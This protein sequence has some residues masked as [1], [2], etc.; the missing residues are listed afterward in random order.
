MKKRSKRIA[1]LLILMVLLITNGC[2]LGIQYTAP[3]IPDIAGKEET[4]GKGSILPQEKKERQL[5]EVVRML[6]DSVSEFFLSYNEDGLLTDIK[7]YDDYDL[8]EYTIWQYMNYDS[9]GRMIE[10]WADYWPNGPLHAYTYREDGKLL[11]DFSA[12]GGCTTEYF[13][14]ENGVN[15]RTETMMDEGPE[16]R[17]HTYDEDGQL[18]GSQV[19][20]TS[21]GTTYVDEYRYTYDDQGRMSACQYTYAGTPCEDH[22]DYQYK[23]FVVNIYKTPNY[24]SVRISLKDNQGHMLWSFIGLENPRYYQDE[25]GYL[26]RIICDDQE[27]YYFLYDGET[28]AESKQDQTKPLSYPIQ[29]D[30]CYI[31]FR[32]YFGYEMQSGDNIQIVVDRM[33]DEGEN[34]SFA[35]YKLNPNTQGYTLQGDFTVEV[36]TGIC[37]RGDITFL[38]DDYYW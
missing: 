24:E 33:G 28:W 30:D 18:I 15:I 17:L 12:E 36:N 29:E 7:E 37:T 23:P 6:G 20:W 26:T 27:I 31:I 34:I 32:N 9:Q 8:T 10:K 38:A 14:D 25:D 2:G 16:V 21:L 4:T 35:I 1:G 22:Y 13:Y 5:T 11:A 3:G 19:T